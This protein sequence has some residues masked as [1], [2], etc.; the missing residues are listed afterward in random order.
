M[1]STASR[2][3]KFFAF[4]NRYAN[5]SFMTGN[6]GK[7]LA[8]LE[9]ADNDGRLRSFILSEDPYRSAFPFFN[10][11]A[12][13]NKD[14]VA[15]VMALNIYGA[16]HKGFAERLNATLKEV[17]KGN[18]KECSCVFVLMAAQLELQSL[19]KSL[20]NFVDKELFDE[21]RASAKSKKVC[22]IL[23][24]IGMVFGSA[25][26]TP[27][28]AIIGLF[29]L[30]IVTVPAMLYGLYSLI[31]WVFM[32]TF[33]NKSYAESVRGV[34]ECLTDEEAEAFTVLMNEVKAPTDETEPPEEKTEEPVVTAETPVEEKEKCF[35]H[36]CGKEIDADAI[37]CI[38][39]GSQVL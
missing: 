26:A 23:L 20:I 6:V 2:T 8:N 16:Q 12:A 14:Q 27:G 33:K 4:F 1:E 37:F 24:R 35:C 39:C 11:Q 9:K 30:L 21:V 10:G 38:H 19:E 17:L 22:A 18:A 13:R 29:P 36:F 15:I 3:N 32:P 7:I 25:I 5:E 28:F 34:G 31:F